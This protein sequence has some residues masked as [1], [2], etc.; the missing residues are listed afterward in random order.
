M[1]PLCATDAPGQ[2]YVAPVGTEL[3]VTGTRYTAEVKQSIA[4]FARDQ[5][6][7]LI[8]TASAFSAN[9]PQLIAALAARQADLSSQSR[10]RFKR[11]ALPTT[12]T[13]ES[14]IA[15][16]AMIGESRMPNVG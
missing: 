1:A 5:N 11:N 12:L 8:V 14:A 3:S 6:G 4:A 16:A 2:D 7:G 13:E 10:M 9:H 15:A